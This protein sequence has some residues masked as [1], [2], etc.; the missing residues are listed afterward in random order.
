M[1]NTIIFD[2]DGTIAD[3][4]SSV[5]RI[6]NN[7]AEHFGYKKVAKDDIRYLQGKK[8]K[9]ILSHLGISMLKLPFWIKKIHSEINKEISNMCPL[10]TF[11]HYCRNYTVT[12]SFILEF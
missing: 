5:V 6:V 1:A 3:T 8:P 4:L 12:S 7:H 11:I 9:E 2:F 10:R